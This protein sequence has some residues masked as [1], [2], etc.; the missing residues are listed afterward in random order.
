M[1]KNKQLI[2]QRAKGKLDIS[3]KKNNLIKLFQSG[4]SK[5]FIPK[6]YHK[7][8]EP[9]ILNTAGGIANGDDFNYIFD[10]KDNSHATFSSQGAERVYKSYNNIHGKITIFIGCLKKL[11]FLIKVD[12]EEN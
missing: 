8:I 3:L 2:L 12:L 10:L 11:F 5:L 6:T 1:I 9:V 7:T 4:S